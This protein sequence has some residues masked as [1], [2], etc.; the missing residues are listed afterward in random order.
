[1]FVARRSAAILVLAGGLTA[2][3]ATPAMAAPTNSQSGLVDLNLQN[4]TVQVPVAVAANI[5]NVAVN[6]LA[7]GLANG[8]A[9][10]DAGPMA[11]ATRPANGPANNRQNGLVN[12][13][14]QNTTVQVP[15]AV[16]ANICNVNVNVLASDILNNAAL[17][18]GTPI[19]ITDLTP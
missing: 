14:L 6:A 8:A 18:T 1:M 5:C 11:T 10:C 4:T 17:C 12:V 13:N 7:Q 19:A 15:A 16:A 9:P 2:G 3:A